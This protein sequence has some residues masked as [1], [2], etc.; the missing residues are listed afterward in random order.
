MTTITENITSIDRVYLY[1]RESGRIVCI[2]VNGDR[3]CAGFTVES[4]FANR[5][6]K[7][8]HS[9]DGAAYRVMTTPEVEEFREFLGK[10]EN[11]VICDCGY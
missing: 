2:R 7:I 9:Y 5:N 8:H 4:S 10:P 1:A 3:G 6:S 11:A